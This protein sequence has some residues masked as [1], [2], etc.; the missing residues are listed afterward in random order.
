DL[1]HEPESTMLLSLGTRGNDPRD[2]EA[3]PAQPD[4]RQE[5]PVERRA[6]ADRL[7]GFHV[8]GGQLR[9][10]ADR[11]A[12]GYR[13]LASVASASAWIARLRRAPQPGRDDQ[14][15]RNGL[16]DVDD[17]FAPP[18]DLHVGGPHRAHEKVLIEAQRMKG[19]LRVP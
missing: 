12:D 7:P 2:E 11:Q 3:S 13:L 14:L 18:S 6:G 8:E 17:G 10:R 19:G 5:R 4:V 15:S 1:C 16:E 9:S